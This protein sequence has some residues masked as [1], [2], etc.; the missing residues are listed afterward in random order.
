MSDRPPK[1]SPYRNFLRRFQS[2][3]E[4]RRPSCALQQQKLWKRFTPKQ[5][6]EELH[7][8]TSELYTGVFGQIRKQ[9]DYKY[10]SHYRKERQWLHDA[11]MEDV[12]L[13][14]AEEAGTK[15]TL[16]VPWLILLVGTREAS[17]HSFVKDLVDSHRLRLR[18]FVTVDPGT[19]LLSYA[20]VIDS[21]H[22]SSDSLTIHRIC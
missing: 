18:R 10:H 12:S 14:Q 22:L 3:S 15:L 13:E 5:S 2:D 9:L 4:E 17:K 6:T 1:S 8:T 7:K 11:V 16:D 20:V 19:C 21:F